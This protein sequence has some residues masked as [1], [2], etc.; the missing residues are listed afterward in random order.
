VT[1][2]HPIRS[3]HPPPP[4]LSLSALFFLSRI[5]VSPKLFLC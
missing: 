4:F 2:E 5:R 1:R 3:A